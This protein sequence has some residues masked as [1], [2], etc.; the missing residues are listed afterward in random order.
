MCVTLH[1][2]NTL[3]NAIVVILLRPRS[4][5]ILNTLQFVILVE[6][7]TKGLSRRLL[8]YFEE[9]MLTIV[10]MGVCAHTHTHTHT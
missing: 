10:V 5:E 9:L 6:V 2:F 4:D 3:L 1:M 7:V 8:L